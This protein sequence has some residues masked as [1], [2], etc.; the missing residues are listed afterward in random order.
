MGSSQPGPV[1]LGSKIKFLREQWNQSLGEVSGTLEIDEKTL[2]AIEEG[3]AFPGDDVLDMVINHFLLTDEQA[4]ELKDMAD[5]ER[6]ISIDALSSSVEDALMKQIVMLMPLDN[7]IVYT[8][9]MQATVNDSGVVLNFMQS[10]NKSQQSTVSRVGMSR[11]HAE[12]IIKV[13]QN[14]LREYDRNQKPKL[15]PSP[16]QK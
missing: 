14:T 2:M 9:S 4:R 5:K 12:K 3:E 6:Q 16:K 8:D 11:E 13:L 1:S 7:K 15:L 10:P